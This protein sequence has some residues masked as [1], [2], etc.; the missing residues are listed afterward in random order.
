MKPSQQR[1][2]EEKTALDEKIE[3]LTSFID[4]DENEIFSTLSDEEQDLLTTQLEIMEQ[5]SKTLTLRIK[6]FRRQGV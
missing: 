2:V 5:Y 4:E 6:L 1:A 3:K